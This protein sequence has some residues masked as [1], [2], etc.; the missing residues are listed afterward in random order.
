MLYRYAL[1]IASGATVT[2]GL[3]V[4]YQLFNLKRPSSLISWSQEAN[5]GMLGG[6]S[7]LVGKNPHLFFKKLPSFYSDLVQ[8]WPMPVKSVTT[9]VT[10]MMG[11]LLA[12]FIENR[13][14]EIDQ[15]NINKPTYNWKRASVFLIFGTFLAGP[16]YTIWFDK[17][18][19]LPYMIYSMKQEARRTHIDSIIRYAADKV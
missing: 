17:I 2:V 15:D 7:L 19:K 11:D 18:D 10:Y 1:Q 6:I 8:R 14:E 9:G 3:S 16:V 4:A 12:Q 13:G 5:V